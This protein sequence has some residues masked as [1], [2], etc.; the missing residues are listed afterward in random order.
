ME[1]I[2]GDLNYGS[3]LLYLDD[4]LVFSSSFSDHLERLEVVFKR[5]R[6]HGLKIKPSKCQFFRRECNY[7]GHVVS[8][9]G[10]ATDPAKTK[11]IR[12]WKQPL[13]EKELRAFL[14]LAGY[15]RRFVKRFSQIATPLHALLTKQGCKQGAAWRSPSSHQQQDFC[16]RWSTDCTNACEEL[17]AKLVSHQFWDTQIL[18]DHS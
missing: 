18:V 1:V 8:A 14:G 16:R 12:D 5:L 7:L 2:L 11:A 6:H 3:L 17:N 10:I 13:T 9:K 4:I 15:Y